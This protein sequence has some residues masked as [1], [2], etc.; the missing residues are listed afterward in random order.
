MRKLIDPLVNPAARAPVTRRDLLLSLL[1]VPLGSRLTAQGSRPSIRTNSLNNVIISVTDMGRSVGF[2][3]KLFGPSTRQGD[4]AI[5]RLARSPRF[6]AVGPVKGG[7]KPGFA[8]YGIAVDDFDADRLAKVLNAAGASAQV[9]MRES[10]KE[11]WVSEP[12]GYR[13]QLVDPSYG[14]GSGPRG[15]VLPAGVKPGG[16]VPLPLQTI[17]HVTISV[18]SGPRS[19]AFYQNILGLPIQAMQGQTAC[20]AVGPGPDFIAFG[21]NAK[22]PTATGA[23]NHACFTIQGFDANRVT[24][25]LADNGLEPIEYG[26][27]AA[28]RPLTCRTRLRQRANNGGGPTHPLG[29]YELYF[30]DPDNISIQIQDVT[31]C[32]GSGANGQICP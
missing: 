14:R 2:Y 16:R 5:F 27:N 24:G 15:D 23:P 22:S 13:I 20:F 19:K 30:N 8:S 10:T 7:E 11:L 12:D 1:A 26:N 28:I 29:S 6:F 21:L 9:S 32:G 31:Y 3:E 4:L 18:Q 17:S 25:I